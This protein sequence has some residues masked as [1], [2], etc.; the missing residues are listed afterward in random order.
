MA[1]RNVEIKA[2]C[3]DPQAVRGVL[4]RCGAE[5]RGTDRQRDTYFHCP[6]GRL[7]LRQGNIERS[8][9]HYRREDRPGPKQAEVTLYRP[10]PDPDLEAVLA[11]ALGVRVVVTKTREIYFIGNVKFH[12]DDV[13]RLGWFVEIE[14]IDADGR[15]GPEALHAQCRRYMRLL[16]IR[17]GDLL[18]A[19]YA[20]MLSGE[21]GAAGGLTP[22]RSRPSGP[23]AGPPR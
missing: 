6:G 8:L 2:R 16:G 20:E 3:G 1:H 17:R 18:S 10:P 21:Q 19:S 14:A 12:L 23:P 4:R 13:D 11:A 7:K 5:F 22:P 9:I 15:F